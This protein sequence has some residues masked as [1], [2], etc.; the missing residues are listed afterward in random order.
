MLNYRS[1]IINNRSRVIIVIID[2]RV[3]TLS[4]P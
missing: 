1:I 2:D 3:L 4:N